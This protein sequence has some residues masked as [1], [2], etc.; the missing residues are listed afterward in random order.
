MNKRYGFTLIELLVVVAIIAVL[1]A[2]LLP[3]LAQAR[4]RANRVVCESNL[5]QMGTALFMYESEY[6]NLPTVSFNPWFDRNNFWQGQLARY[7]GF[8]GS[9]V[10]D[11][12]YAPGNWTGDQPR[13]P[14]RVVKVFQ[15]PVSFKISNDVYWYGNCY[16]INQYLWTTILPNRYISFRKL[17]LPDLTFVVMDT[18]CYVIYDGT[19]A[20]MGNLHKDLKNVLYCDLHVAG[21]QE[22]DGY[23]DGPN[24]WGDTYYMWCR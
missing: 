7:L 10:T 8:S 13:Y 21:Y 1:V 4:G 18:S 22:P 17:Q 15:C 12:T 9:P 24:L 2:M 23:W 5:R 3:A 14:D 20:S 16:G 6:A 11:L 19:T